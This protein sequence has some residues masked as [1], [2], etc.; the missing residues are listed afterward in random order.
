MGRVIL[1][2]N[3]LPD[4][5]CPAVSNEVRAVYNLAGDLTELTY[6]DGR[7]ITQTW[8]GAE[9]LTNINYIDWSGTAVNYSYLLSATYNSDGTPSLLAFG[10]GVT[11][12][13]TENNRLQLSEIKAVVNNQTI[14]DKQFRYTA[15]CQ[16]AN[17]GNVLQILDVLNNAD[18]QAFCYDALNRIASFTNGNGSMQQTFSTDAWGKVAQTGTLTS[19][20]SYGTNNRIATGGYGYDAAGNVTSFY[21]GITTNSY[22]YDAEGRLTTINGGASTYTY[23]AFDQRVR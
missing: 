14:F 12:N 23:S 1:K 9:H 22:T 7:H 21:N 6:P 18:S 4:N 2:A 16:S 20:V 8:N 10:N 13:R 19:N 15:S 11:E 17:N 5:C 3:T